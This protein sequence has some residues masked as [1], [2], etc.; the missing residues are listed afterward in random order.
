[1]SVLAGGPFIY[2]GH[3]D[4]IHTWN[5][6][7]YIPPDITDTTDTTYI[8]Y[9]YQSVREVGYGMGKEVT[10]GMEHNANMEQAV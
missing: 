10:A 1:M 9:I 8:Y 4:S 5:D 6:H 7:L 3:M 2:I